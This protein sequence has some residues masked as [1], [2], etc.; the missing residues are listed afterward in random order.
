MNLN[1]EGKNI[2]YT[3]WEPITVRQEEDIFVRKC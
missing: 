3:K 2:G 1:L